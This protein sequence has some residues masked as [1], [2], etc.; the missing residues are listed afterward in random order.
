MKTT[1]SSDGGTYI[2]IN[3]KL[4]GDIKKKWNDACLIIIK[5]NDENKKYDLFIEDLNQKKFSNIN[6]SFRIGREPSSNDIVIFDE[7]V[8]REHAKITQNGSKFR[9]ADR[10]STN[11]TYVNGKLIRKTTVLKNHDK[12]LVGNTTLKFLQGDTESL[13]L[14]NLRN[15][16][17]IDGLTGAY[18]KHYFVDQFN[19]SFLL[20]KRYKK[21]LSLLIF[22]IDDFKNINDTYGHAAGDFILSE[23]GEIIIKKIRATDIFARVGGEEFAVICPET[24]IKESKKLADKLLGLVKGQEYIFEGKKISVTISIGACEFNDSMKDDLEMYKHCDSLLYK[25]KKTGKDRFVSD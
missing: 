13:F 16:I 5:G 1:I 15:K 14:D 20:S 10:K 8:S 2:Y 17:N 21:K 18:N 6:S 19:K 11:G 24:D 4:T 3:K 22:D 9:I 25:A 23:I 7:A 12:I